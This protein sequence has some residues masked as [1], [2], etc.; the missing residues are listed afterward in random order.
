MVFEQSR[1]GSPVHA[2]YLSEDPTSQSLPLASR[3]T[4]RIEIASATAPCGK[5][6]MQ[7]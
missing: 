3:L 7:A 1:R 4:G 5:H 6:Y 2:E